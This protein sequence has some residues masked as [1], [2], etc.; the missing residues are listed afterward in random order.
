[1]LIQEWPAHDYAIGSYIQ[2]SIADNYLNYLTIKPTDQV[3]DIGCGN[4]VFSRKI[5]DKIPH[6]SLLGIDASE[7]MLQLARKAMA[8]YPNASCQQA[9]VLTM[10]F[11]K[12]FDYIV[13]FW[14]LHWC[15][16][17][18]ETVFLNIY[19]A[20]KPGGK[21]LTLF[22]SGDDSFMRSYHTIKS[23]G[24]F[25]CLNQ[26]TPPVDFQNFHHLEERMHALP[27]Q[28]II[29]EHFKH[30]LMLPSLDIF[31]KFVNGLAFFHGQIPSDKIGILNEAL[32]R[33][34]EQECHEKHQ[35]KYEF[36]L[37]IYV[38]RAEK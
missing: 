11:D 13:S 21:V 5:L 16:F 26:F 33:A 28:Q 34:Y 22:P 2:A 6:G 36:I 37:P 17:D 30:E 29:V 8:N 24:E 3:L 10:K 31:R 9:D 1:M 20:L 27:F 23:S 14:C 18:I 12:Q 4:G 7:N 32:V 35:D 19:H 25:S 15:A 38:I